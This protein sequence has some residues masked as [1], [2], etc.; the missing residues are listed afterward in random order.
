MPL[1]TGRGRTDSGIGQ[2]VEGDGG[3][4][5]RNEPSVGSPGLMTRRSATGSATAATSQ[6]SQ[7]DVHGPL[8]D[9]TGLDLRQYAHALLH[10]T[11]VSARAQVATASAT[12]GATRGSKAEGTM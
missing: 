2:D 11:V 7:E 10:Q 3:F 8:A 6:P 1:L 12:A 5:C 9:T 4:L